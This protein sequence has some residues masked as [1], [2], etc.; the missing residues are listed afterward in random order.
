MTAAEMASVADKVAHPP[1]IPDV[2]RDP[3]AARLRRG[4]RS[5]QP[6]DLVW[7]DPGSEAGMTAVDMAI[8]ANRVSPPPVIRTV[9]R[10]PAA[11]RLRGGG[12]FSAQGLGLAGSRLAGRDDGGGDGLPSP[13][14]S[15]PT[16]H[17][18]L[19]PGSS[20]RASARRG[21]S[22]QPKDLV[23]LDPGSQA[24]MTAVDMA[25]AADNKLAHPPVIP[26]V[27]RDPAAVRLRGAEAS[28]QPKDLV[29]LDPG[30]EAGMTAVDMAIVSNKPHHPSSRT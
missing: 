6:K 26:D 8:V 23:L 2:I 15:S 16:R 28:F 12:V 22:F 14:S 3:A 20:S 29:W 25:I 19:D 13:T 21:E 17:P 10:D 18:G 30:S 24:G 9:I 27:I 5:F 11:A 1:V 4:G 7:L